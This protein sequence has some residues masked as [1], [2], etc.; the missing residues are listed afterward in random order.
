MGK[1]RQHGGGGIEWGGG[2]GR[3]RG[4]GRGDQLANVLGCGEIE[5]RLGGVRVLS[6]CCA[7]QGPKYV[8]KTA[9]LSTPQLPSPPSLPP[10][11][12]PLHGLLRAGQ[13]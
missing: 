11:S 7:P 8:W 13:C 9:A 5:R 12:P 6:I 1:E 3:Q 10:A 2:G 4:R